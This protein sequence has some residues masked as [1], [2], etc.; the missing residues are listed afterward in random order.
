M[1]ETGLFATLQ[2][3]LGDFYFLLLISDN[4]LQLSALL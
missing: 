3:M 2:G 1:T 4:F